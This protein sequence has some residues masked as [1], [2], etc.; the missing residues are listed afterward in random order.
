MT[1]FLVIY[2]K[3]MFIHPSLN[4]LVLYTQIYLFLQSHLK[5]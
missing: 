3:I 2:K 4:I 1:L 5:S